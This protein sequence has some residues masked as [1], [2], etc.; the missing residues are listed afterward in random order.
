MLQYKSFSS[1]HADA[2]ATLTQIILI[3]RCLYYKETL[4]WNHVISIYACEDVFRS[5]F[6][7]TLGCGW[8]GVG[9]GFG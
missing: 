9:S 3:K 4:G 6:N 1:L 2:G 8:R 5:V 7:G